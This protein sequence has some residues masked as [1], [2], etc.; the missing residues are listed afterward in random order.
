MRSSSLLSHQLTPTLIQQLFYWI[1]YISVSL[2]EIETRS[3]E[4]LS[5]SDSESG[6]YLHKSIVVCKDKTLLFVGPSSLFSIPVF[7]F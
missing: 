2:S 4:A 1:I 6:I 3:S 5:D 7:Y